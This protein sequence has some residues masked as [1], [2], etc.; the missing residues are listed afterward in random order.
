MLKLMNEMG[1]SFFLKREPIS[2]ASKI[3]FYT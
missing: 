1:V 2:V 3:S